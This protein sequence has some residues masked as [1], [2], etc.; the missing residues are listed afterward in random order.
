MVRLLAVLCLVMPGG[1]VSATPDPGDLLHRMT[2]VAR[3]LH[4]RGQLLYAQDDSI[5]TLEILQG[6]FGNV[7]YQ[8]LTSLDGDKASL[9]RQGEQ[10]FR[11]HP[12]NTVTRLAERSGV[13]PI[14]SARRFAEVV[15]RH[16]RLALDGSGRVAGRGTWRVAVT[17]MDEHRYGY[18]LWIDEE[19]HLLLR[20]DI[21]D[22]SGRWLE[23]LEFVNLELNPE[24][25]KAHFEIPAAA[26]EKVLETV[27]PE[28]H[29]QGRVM[30]EPGW[31]PA[32]FSPAEE[33]LRLAT[34]ESSPV[35]ARTWTDGLTAFTL[36]LEPLSGSGRREARLVGPTVALSRPFAGQNWQ[37]TL[38]G[39]IP[40]RTA[41]KVLG[42]LELRV[43]ND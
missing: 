36:F 17:P 25:D 3:D 37:V 39:E 20:A 38:V 5:R 19:T 29:P 10:V 6:R 31:V 12:D 2:E 15:P 42:S 8:R 43:R 41:E 32:G 21:L 4:F 11:L 14:G 7:P 35:N 13:S 30:A 18:R 33:D 40:P 24:L 34:G 22:G 27:M 16:Y 9:V 26:E 28:S 1:P 23:R